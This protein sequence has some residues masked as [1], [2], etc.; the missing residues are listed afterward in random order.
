MRVVHIVKVTG[1]AGAERHLLMLLSGLRGPRLSWQNA[2][3]F[4]IRIL[5]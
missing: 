4:S 2:M 1:I 5:P 3:M